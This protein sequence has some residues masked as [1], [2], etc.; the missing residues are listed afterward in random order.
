MDDHEHTPPL[1]RRLAFDEWVRDHARG[2]LNGELTM[3]LA[4]VVQQVTEL[5]KSGTLTVKLSVTPMGPGGRVGARTVL[6]TSDITA[7]PP[8]AAGESSIFYVG[9]E[10]GLFRDDPYNVRLPGAA[11]PADTEPA[12]ALPA[13][14]QPAHRI[15]DQS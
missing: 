12:R 14:D 3:A 8:K 5:D 4:D 1:N 2:T 9:E 13:D 11:V 10:G 6:I 7:R 15:E